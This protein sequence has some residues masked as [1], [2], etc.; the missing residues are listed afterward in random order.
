M[1]NRI[2]K[3]NIAMLLSLLLVF[4]FSYSNAYGETDSKLWE[5]QT[6]SEPMKEW[7]IKF[8]YELDDSVVDENN[9]YVT[10]AGGNKVN[11][12]FSLEN[13]NKII[14]IKPNQE[15]KK[16]AYYYL[17]IDDGIKTK[18]GKM[19]KKKIKMPF[20]FKEASLTIDENDTSKFND[21]VKEYIFKDIK[22]LASKDSK[23][24]RIS[25]LKYED[26]T[27]GE[28][29]ENFGR[30]LSP[31]EIPITLNGNFKV[32]IGYASG[33]NSIGIKKSS[34]DEYI[35]I[36]NDAHY[37]SKSNYGDQYIYEKFAFL[38][39]FNNE[40]LTI[41]NDYQ[42]PTRIA[43]F[44]FVKATAEEI[45][46]YNTPDEGEKGKRVIYDNDG[47]SSFCDGIFHDSK[48]LDYMLVSPLAKKNVGVL[49]WCLGTTGLLN[50]NSKYAGKAFAS[51]D[52]YNSQ[53]RD[54]DK[55][56]KEQVLNI[57]SEG[58]SP[59]EFLAEFGEGDGLDVYAS[60]R[61]NTFYPEDK[62]GYLNGS[63]YSSYKD[64]KQKD[65][66][67]LSYLYPKTRDYIL[68]VLK[69]ASSFKYVDGVTLDF[70]RYPVVMTSEANQATKVKI[71]TDF[72][73][74]VRREIP[75]KKIVAR[76]PYNNYISYGYDIKTWIK[77][78]LVDIIVPSN[79]T[80]DDFFDIKPFVNMV[81]G[82]KVKLYIGICADVKGHDLT[83]EEE[84]LIKAGLYVHN[85]SYLTLHEYMVRA[86]E[87]YKAGGDGIFLFNTS[88]KIYINNNTPEETKFLGDKVAMTKWYT[89]HYNPK[90]IIKKVFIREV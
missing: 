89:F 37:D 21:Q 71:M 6:I 69:E 13:N 1:C 46:L 17:H 72:M 51:F 16:G 28:L 66:Y 31:L 4:I 48:S 50:Y 90:P 29:L 65:E 49:N 25:N 40:S 76:I 47:Y 54:I 39:N 84:E 43:Y 41:K 26:G 73:R 61:M 18:N 30:N 78:G 12:S 11:T 77:E 22:S 79:I 27:K 52:K 68:N 55:R 33:T 64:V 80:V 2:M 38:D 34:N 36:T 62:Y 3:L 81:K 35:S 44:R 15:Y 8:N 56:A 86:A 9:T 32:Y 59:L 60:L 20:I 23:N 85:K 45:K 24:W 42:N 5:L 70:C 82:S 67:G 53:L 75:N 10:D 74:K 83:K 87:V 88:Y 19:L 14:V 58:K 57:L 7:S 63:I